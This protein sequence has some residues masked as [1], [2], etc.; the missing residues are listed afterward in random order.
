MHV[1]FRMDE[2]EKVFQKDKNRDSKEK[3][4]TLPYGVKRFKTCPYCN[5]IM[6]IDQLKEKEVIYY[7]K[8]CAKK[9]T[10]VI[11]HSQE[12]FL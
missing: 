11:D 4:S 5:E 2:F 1:E 12:G 10:L 3:S 7:C 9:H 8:S 6:E